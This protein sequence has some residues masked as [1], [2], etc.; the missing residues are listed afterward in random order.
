MPTTSFIE[1]NRVATTAGTYQHTAMVSHRGVP[2]SFGMTTSG[3][4]F[5]SV[6]DMSNTQG[7]AAKDATNDRAFW[8]PLNEGTEAPSVLHFPRELGQAGFGVVPNHAIEPHDASNQP[9][10]AGTDADGDL[11]GQDGAKLTE[12]AIAERTDPHFSST[13]RLGAVQPFQALSDGKYVYL[14]RQSIAANHA[15]N[16]N[17]AVVDD[18]LLVDRFVLS[19]S[20][21]KPSREVRYQRSRHKTEPASRKDTLSAVDMDGKPFYEPTRELAFANHLANGNF[22]VLLIPGADPEEQRWQIF[23]Q[24]SSTEKIN[25]F[26]VRFDPSIV[27]DASDSEQFVQAFIERYGLDSALIADV[28]AEIL[29]GHDDGQIAATLGAKAPY[30]AKG[31][32]EDALVEVV[33]TLRTGVIKDDF[34]PTSTSTWPLIAYDSGG[35]IESQYAPGGVLDPKY[36]FKGQN[37]ELTPEDSPHVLRNGL[38][39]CYY[40][41]QE[42][43]PD[44]KPIKNKACVMLAMGLEDERGDK[45]IG[46]LNFSV[47][48]S[49]RLSRLTTD[50]VNLPDINVQALDENPY[51]DLAAINQVAW[52]PPQKM[53]LLDIDPNGLSTSGGVL[54][55]AYTSSDFASQYSDAVEADAPYIFDDSLGR[56][57]LYFKGKNDNFFVLYFNPQGSKKVA[58][59]QAGSSATPPLTLTPRLDRDM[60]I[61]ASASVAGNT[62]ALV[63]D[64]A[65][66]TVERWQ[67]LPRRLGQIV[68]VLNGT[69]SLPLARLEPLGNA[70]NP[71]LAYQKGTS[72]NGTLR[73]RTTT[74]N[75]L[76]FQDNALA[77]NLADGAT[78]S[79]ALGSLSTFLQ[80]N[81]GLR[82]AN[83]SFTLADNAQVAVQASLFYKAHLG[84]LVDDA[85]D[86]DALWTYLGTKALVQALP[87]VNDRSHLRAQALTGTQASLAALIQDAEL[88]G[89]TLQLLAVGNPGD[90]QARRA[91]L[92]QA[93]ITLILEVAE[94]RLLAFAVHDGNAQWVDGLDAGL[95]VEAVYDYAANFTC[96]PANLGGA[97]APEWEHARSYLFRA[98]AVF[99]A[100]ADASTEIDA[101]FDYEYAVDNTIGQWEDWDASLAVEFTPSSATSGALLRT[102]A[103]DKL[104]QLQPTRKGLSAE[105]WVKPAAN[106]HQRGSVIYFRQGDQHYSLGVEKD[107]ADAS[108]YRGV[109]TFGD[110][111]YRTNDSYPFVSGGGEY[112]RHL[113]FS[114]K[115]YWGYRLASGTQTINCGNDDSLSL[116]GEQSIE[117]SA[118]IDQVG[119]LLERAGEYRLSVNAANEVEFSCG[120]T[121]VLEFWVDFAGTPTAE[122]RADTA[123]FRYRNG[124]WEQRSRPEA[125]GTLGRFFK[126]SLIR[127]RRQPIT[128]PTSAEYPITGGSESGGS[129][130]KWYENK[131]GDELTR[132]MAER[133]DQMGSSAMAAQSNLFGGDLS[134]DE[135][136][137][138]SYFYTLIVVDGAGNTTEWTTDAAKDASAPFSLGD[139]SM[140]GGGFVGTLGDVRY[141]ARA[142]ATSEAKAL[143]LSDN[144]SGLISHWRIAAGEGKYLYDNVGE[145]HGV[146]P[147]ASGWTGSPQA[148]RPGMFVF[149]VDGSPV[150]T[151]STEGHSPTGVDQLSLGGVKTGGGSQ[152]HFSGVLE[153]I[154]I[155]NL[156]RSAE[157]I[158][159]NAFG[160]LKGEW[161]QLLA[162]YTFDTP[163]SGATVLDAS[164]SS[165]Q[166]TAENAAMLRELLSTA[167][168]ATEIPQIRSALT[169]VITDYNGTIRS[170]PAVVEY[171]DV[172][173][174]DDGTLNGILKRCY[175]FVDASGVWNRV[176]GYKVGNL[177]SQWYGQ[178]QFSPQV[179]GYLEGP[180]PVPGENFPVGKDADVDTYAYKLDNSVAFTQAEEVA[181]NYSTSKEAGWQVAVESEMKLGLGLRTLIA[182][183][184]LGLSFKV[185]MGL[186]TSSNWE[187][188]GSRS[189]SYE[190]GVSVS[191][192]RSLSAALAGYDNGKA[193]AERYYEL[194]N[195][196][197]CLVKSK[198]ADIYLLRLA[199]NDALV[200]ISWQPNPDIPEDVNIIPFPI[201]PLYVKQ[202]T[203]DGKV[204]ETTDAHYPQAQ[205]A[206]GQ[207]SYF[208]PREAYAL[209][210]KIERE[211][212]EL[213]HYFDDSFD[214]AKT[215]AHFDA[216]AATTGVLQLAAFA[217]PTGALATSLINQIGGQLATQLGYNNT[218]IKNDLSEMGSQRN[219]VNTYVWT[220]EGGFYAESTEVAQTQQETYSNTTSLALGGGLGLALEADGGPMFEQKTLFSSGSSFTLTKSRTQESSS[221]FGLDVSVDIPTSPRY[222]YA[223]VDG[224]TLSKGLIS[225]GTVDAYRF[226]TFYLEP[227]GKNFI[228]LFT[229]VIDPI[230]LDESPDPNA[231]ALRQAAG[232]GD[233]VRPCWRVMHRVTYVSRILPEFQPEAPP[234]LER[235]MQIAGI[236]S[237]Y[238]LI[239][240]FEPYVAHLSDPAA[241]FAAIETIVDTK[242]VEFKPYKKQIKEYLALY[243]DVGQA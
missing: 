39:A 221:S 152:D 11:V 24:D 107:S 13:A 69:Q 28:R 220:V 182:P 46:V 203:L 40:Y 21:L 74:A 206:Y 207:Y 19:G 137:G 166:L 16:A 127:S 181:Y 143:T 134:Q 10:I 176:T 58:V 116:G 209:K 112:W 62:A 239:K 185:K 30:N 235:T 171:G 146:A 156:P 70:A 84:G 63:L 149:Y 234:S 196:G 48:D 125:L 138:T 161:E 93:L 211:K 210:K 41:Q 165:A 38:S 54:R 81:R 77:A 104:T 26:N 105:A 204:G 226:M 168:V 1:K 215:G 95:E 175:A 126:I 64:S 56:V 117:F 35:N 195:T 29:A 61:D 22:C 75:N 238:M 225:A 122:Q 103:A 55:F 79:V 167:P 163:M 243:F 32:P 130:E 18:T 201:N 87:G 44:Q 51:R 65:G 124:E 114:R 228:D 158:T 73:I 139:L 151:S 15:N 144:A 193:G 27:F 128:T 213:R 232:S 178:A 184:G 37:D 157:Q 183:L 106:L 57:N 94:V 25:S 42:V 160:R 72:G 47:A 101:S 99:A 45:Y 34:R 136:G 91:G 113:A 92:K 198:T 12:Q 205:G 17:P 14:F 224:R 120:D 208:K 85:G 111:L 36:A 135:D 78:H 121:N 214:V 155:W 194:G 186:A 68:G 9:I 169:G 147:D 191:T 150:A 200:S 177:V 199:H 231:Q 164:T 222:K 212:M 236:E 108:R 49:G 180:P 170:R 237:N 223:G 162:N 153:E 190:Q 132:G 233:R 67:H 89:L 43:G 59:S 240:R 7:N 129:G 6:L 109:A 52:Q 141:W 96:T 3:R 2:I 88:D 187:T 202:G 159:D 174:N 4:I 23:T 71:R 118:R 66:N 192:E 241:F 172:Q 31:I 50:N 173:K 140:G 216:A 217:G 98:K 154:R 219:L 33:Y 102:S 145:S 90:K 179:I 133:Q 115:R 119:T 97:S 218:Q 5:Y 227:K 123:N 148:N 230:W 142:L 229:K 20:V 80:N 53:H 189:Q 82:V 83:K 110:V 86:I 197:Y 60:T 131:S 242:M 188:S 8:S 100:G 76:V